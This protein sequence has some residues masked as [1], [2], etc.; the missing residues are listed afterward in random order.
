VVNDVARC[1]I[2]GIEFMEGIVKVAI[3]ENAP[4][5]E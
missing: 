2:A 1:F 4:P 5:L 3:K